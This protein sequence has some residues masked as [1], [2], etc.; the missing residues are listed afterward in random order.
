MNGIVDDDFEDVGGS[1]KG[2]KKEQ[3]KEYSGKS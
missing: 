2:Q 1:G 3:G